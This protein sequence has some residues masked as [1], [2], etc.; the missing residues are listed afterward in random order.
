MSESS[1]TRRSLSVSDSTSGRT[2]A[3]PDGAV[4]GILRAAPGRQL[5]THPGRTP[6]R[7]AQPNLQECAPLYGA[8]FW[9]GRAKT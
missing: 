2:V 8:D 4:P 7:G 3:R 1:S 9:S 5:P 6:P